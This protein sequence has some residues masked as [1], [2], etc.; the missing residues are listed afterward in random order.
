[1]IPLIRRM[2]FAPY[3][4]AKRFTSKIFIEEFST[5][6]KC[7]FGSNA[8]IRSGNYIYGNIK[9]GRYSYISGPGCIVFDCE[10][11]NFCSIARQVNIGLPDHQV[12]FVSTSPF[13]KPIDYNG[14]QKHAPRIGNDVWIGANAIICRGVTIGD[15]A[16]IGAGAVVTKDVPPYSISAGVPARHIRYRFSPEEIRK[17]EELK[18]YDWDD[19]KLKKYAPLSGDIKKFLNE[20]ENAK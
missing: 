1:M 5:S 2:I 7:S 14:R 11:G 16:V 20:F 10:I 12:S 17:L 6:P 9:M 18:R 13:F 19:D 4:L 15:G 8:R 3:W